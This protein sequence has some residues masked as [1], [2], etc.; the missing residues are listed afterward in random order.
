MGAHKRIQRS[1]A[2]RYIAAARCLETQP[3]GERGLWK[4]ERVETT[5]DD[6]RRARVG[7][8]PYLTILSRR[9]MAALHQD[10]GEV[11]MEDSQSE[12][13]QHLPIWLS[14]KGRVLVTGLGLGCVVRGLL[15]NPAVEHITVVEI[16]SDIIAWIWPEFHADERLLLLQGDAFEIDWPPGTRYDFA[17][18]DIYHEEEHE[19]V[20]HSKLIARY[21]DMCAVQGAWGMPRWWR[22][23]AAG[24]LIRTAGGGWRA[25]TLPELASRDG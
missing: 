23:L 4:L 16:D 22:R 7:P 3:V 18:H 1:R 5:P 8:Y 13:R 2:N 11:V 10:R 12:L 6:A 20:L 17:W 19:A 15:A 9:T 14:A 21:A 24:D 25:N